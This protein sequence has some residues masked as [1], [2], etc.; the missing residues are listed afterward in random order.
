[1]NLVVDIGNTSL[2][3]S[4]TTDIGIKKVLQLK[5]SKK[6]PTFIIK[7]LKNQFKT[8]KII[9]I[10]SVV[11]EIDKIIKENL[12]TYRKDLIFINKKKLTSLVHRRVN[13]SQLGNDRIINVL[14]AIKIYPKSKS[15][16]IIDLGTATTLDI[17]INY[18]Y[19]G[20]V[21]LPGRT[22]SYENLISLAS[23]IKNMKFSNDTNILGKN[24]SQALM[25]GFNIGYKLM[26]ESYLKLIKTTYKRNFKVIFTGG[27]ASTI[28]NKKTKFI[29]REDLTLLGTS[30]YQNFLNE[31]H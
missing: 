5:Y 27:Y 24:T 10:C 2:K 28:T 15:F 4:S 31:K 22:T 1:M 7:F 3:Y 20:G 26:I 6:K 30:F 19:F 14:S 23:G 13:L 21:I 25:S 29:Y 9:Y 12:K 11:S 18:K 16:I 8:H 17:I